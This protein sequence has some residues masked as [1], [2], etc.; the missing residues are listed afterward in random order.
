MNNLI[1]RLL[2]GVI[3]LPLV[4]GLVWLGGWWLTVLVLVAAVVAVHEFITVARPLRPLAPALYLGVALALVLAQTSG[5]VWMLGG[6]LSTFVLAFAASVLAKTRAPSTV[7]IGATVLGAGWIGFGLA[8]LLLLRD[9]HHHGRLLTFAVLLTVW[10]ADTFA[11][12]GGRLFGRRKL[13]PTLSPGK[14]WE[15]FVIGSIAGIFVSFV[16]LYDTRH[17]YLRVW[18]AVVLGVVVVLASV[19]G[20]LFESMLKR[21]MQVKDTGRLLG[22]HGGIIDRIDALLFAGPAA[23][24]LVL[25]L[26]HG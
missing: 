20:D 2:V 3:G 9:I 26:G 13:A 1:S 25:G 5:I 11:Y 6:M 18:E 21:D 17:T 4:L 19:V 14:T 12:F 24:Y 16:A 15:G 10:A 7:A 23:Y 22:G 8:H